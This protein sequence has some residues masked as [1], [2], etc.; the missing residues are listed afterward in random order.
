MASE[1]R[2]VEASGGESSRV[3]APTDTELWKSWAKSWADTQTENRSQPNRCSTATTESLESLESSVNAI[4]VSILDCFSLMSNGLVVV[5][6][7]FH[8]E[9]DSGSVWRRADHSNHYY[10]C[11]SCGQTIRFVHRIRSEAL[12]RTMAER[13]KRYPFLM[14]TV[15]IV[16]LKS[17][18]V[19]ANGKPFETICFD[20]RFNH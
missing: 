11:Y 16:N 8:C 6:N 15:L 9:N 18:S 20:M 4:I 19:E 1:S 13:C 12:V 7:V 2:R 10:Q 14:I 5:L 3:E 17:G